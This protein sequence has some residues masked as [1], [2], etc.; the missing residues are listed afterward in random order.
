MQKFTPCKIALFTT[1]LKEKKEDIELS[2]E[3]SKPLSQ[4][5]LVVL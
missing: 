1:S 2:V 5:L 4:F 3:F